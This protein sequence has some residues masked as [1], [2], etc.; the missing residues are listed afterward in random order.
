MTPAQNSKNDD[1]DDLSNNNNLS[2]SIFGFFKNHHKEPSKVDYRRRT[3]KAPFTSFIFY[4][5]YQDDVHS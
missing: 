1:D 4:H 5:R 3:K 2:N